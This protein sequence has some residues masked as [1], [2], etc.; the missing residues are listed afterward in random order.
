MAKE[1]M[2]EPPQTFDLSK[3]SLTPELLQSFIQES[4]EQLESA[5]GSLLVVEQLKGGANSKE[6]IA[7]AFRSIHT[8]KGNSG[9]LGLVPMEQMSHKMESVLEQ[10]KEGTLA[11]EKETIQVLLKVVDVLRTGI[12]SLAEKQTLDLPDYLAIFEEL[13]ALIEEKAPAHEEELPPQTEAPASFAQNNGANFSAKTPLPSSAQTENAAQ[14]S[15]T[16]NTQLQQPHIRV[17]V[18]KMDRLINLLEELV[19][20]EAM[21]TH[22]LET[23]TDS[24][25]FVKASHQLNKNVRNLQE[26]VM[27]MRM[28]PI[29]G[30]FRKMLRV[31]HDVSEKVSKNVELELQGEETEMD[32]NLVEQLADPLLHLIRNAVDHGIDTPEEREQAGKPFLAKVFLEAKHKGNEIW[33]TIS[34]DG[35]GLNREKILQRAKEQG[36]VSS[37]ANPPDGEVWKMVFLPGFSTVEAV[38]DFSGR[39]MG[40]DV[41]KRN[42]E[43]LRGH[44]DVTSI[45]GKSS[46]FLLRIPLTLAIIEGMLIRVGSIVYV[47]PIEGVRESLQPEV[48]SIT[49]TADAMEFIQIRNELLPVVRLHRLHDLEPD[50]ARLWEGILI[51]IEDGQKRVCLFIDEVVGERQVVVKGLPVYFGEIPHLAGCTILGDGEISL[52]LDPN[53]LVNIH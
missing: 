9:F 32:R 46:T 15:S 52:I 39:G 7:T 5:E 36:L 10:M 21:V 25:R 13:T 3:L 38:T 14:T 16:K 26:V 30:I 19:I 51:V 17:S 8:L 37:E 33:I 2:A 50:S 41:V 43:K 27:S 45:P 29:A 1:T 47:I 20:S 35:R 44:V 22:N 49:K 53:S 4:E 31:V 6:F 48:D 12:H 28:L 18:E 34:D 23:D 11:F 40:L 42:V 24:E